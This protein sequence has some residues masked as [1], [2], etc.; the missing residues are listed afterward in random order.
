MNRE[1]LEEG[2]R[3]GRFVIL[4]DVNGVT[5]AMAVGSIAA[6]CETDDGSL[7]MLP[8]GRMVHVPRAMD[9]V[10]GWLGGG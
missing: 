4:R 3:V 2:M 1:L 7:L 6:V 9:V 10:L 8:G 5:H